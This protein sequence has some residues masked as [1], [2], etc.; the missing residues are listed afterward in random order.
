MEKIK[1]TCKYCNIE[2]QFLTTTDIEEEN[3]KIQQTGYW[4]EGTPFCERLNPVDKSNT[5]F[6]ICDVSKEKQCGFYEPK[7]GEKI[8]NE[9]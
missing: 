8:K 2:R 4:S 9:T 1:S 3:Y 5:P 7:K 6:L